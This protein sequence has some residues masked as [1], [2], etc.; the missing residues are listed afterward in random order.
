VQP[1]CVPEMTRADWL[2]RR[3]QGLGASDIPS[4]VGCGW[5]TP[6]D[7]YR[8]KTAAELVER[9]PTERMTLGTVLEPHIVK[10]YGDVTGWLPEKA[11]ALCIHPDRPWQLATPDGLLD[12]FR[13]L[14]EC[15]AIFGPPGPEW[16]EPMTDQVPDR[17]LAQA[18]QQMGVCGAEL[19]D[20]A[21]L[22]VGFEFRIYRVQFDR[23]LYTLLT[24]AGA[25]FW[26]HV[27]RR[28]VITEDWTST[29]AGVIEPKLLRVRVGQEAQ[30]DADALKLAEEFKELRRV[31]KEAGEEADQIKKQ[32][33]ALVGDREFG[34]F[35]GGG[36][37]RRQI[38]ERKPYTVDGSSYELLTVNLNAKKKRASQ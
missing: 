20:V 35:P 23:D 26:E 12:G 3:Q 37:V 8:E 14:L 6:A 4:V 32:L 16:G 7:L 18:Q 31:E 29:Y 28:R 11:P 10:R 30:L 22:F 13:Q 33:R 1:I 38:V 21:A 2:K 17:V 34:R 9:P 27:E 15:K 19:V 36:Y 5:N 25:E 24:D